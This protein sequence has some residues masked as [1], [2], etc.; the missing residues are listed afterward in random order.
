M[1]AVAPPVWT[2]GDLLEQSAAAIQLFRDLRMREPLEAYLDQF[3]ARRAAVENLIETTADLTQLSERATAVLADE[4]MQE[5]VR[6]LAGP[7]IS[8]DDLKVVA[9]VASL[10]PGRIG[11]NAEDARRAV[12]TVLL[13][14][15]RRRFPWIGE[16]R[17]ATDAEREAAIAATAGL[18]AAR[19]VMTARQ[20]EGKEAQ[21]LA[22][23]TRLN[24][25]GFEQVDPRTV[26]TLNDAPGPG[27]FC[28][29]S[30]F[31][32]RKADTVV[33]LW[34]RRVMA[35]ECKVSNS[36][37]NSIKRLNNDAA[38]KAKIWIAEFGNLQVVPS[39]T[40]S[41]VF[42]L[43]NLKSAQSDGLTIWW[44]HDLDAMA[45]WIERT[46]SR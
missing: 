23:A 2:D 22:V 46:R 11:A 24:A 6:Y 28:R 12:E 10:A 32:S 4:D 29:E 13:G 36:S 15:D 7:P 39:A 27:Q 38:V 19:R 5:A 42:K 37:T 17:A 20:N 31:G 30:M 14:L 35:I 9:E 21:E 1:T 44:A 41:G 34:D 45:D 25:A 43:R 33:G 16:G 3:D 40:L 26:A 8:S 18:I